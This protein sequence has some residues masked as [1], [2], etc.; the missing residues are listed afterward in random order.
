MFKNAHPV[1]NLIYVFVCSKANILSSNR[2]SNQSSQSSVPATPNLIQQF[3]FTYPQPGVN[4]Y[5]PF[6]SSGKYSQQDGSNKFPI[7][8]LTS[9][10]M[11]TSASDEMNYELLRNLEENSN[12][13]SFFNCSI[14]ENSIE[15][16]LFMKP[17]ASFMSP[18]GKLTVKSRSETDLYFDFKPETTDQLTKVTLAVNQRSKIRASCRHAKNHSLLRKH[19]TNNEDIEAY[20]NKMVKSEMRERNIKEPGLLLSMASGSFFASSQSCV[21]SSA[22]QTV[23]T[24]GLYHKCVYSYFFDSFFI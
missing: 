17:S 20:R 22:T 24:S 4:P 9:H 14:N 12:H 16:D 21:N 3:V 11:N 8:N 7:K 13:R 2:R 23:D 10:F 6:T 18:T 1:Q 19:I 5:D 15:S